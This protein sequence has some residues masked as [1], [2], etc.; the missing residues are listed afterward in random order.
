M[1]T[2]GFILL[3]TLMLTF[4]CL[5]VAAI[6]Y[7]FVQQHN[8][9]LMCTDNLRRIFTALEMYEIERGTLPRLAFFPNDPRQDMDSINVALEEFGAHG[10][11]CICPTTH[12]SHKLLGL[13][14]LWNHDLSGSKLQEDKEP[15]WMLVEINALSDQVPA[16]HLGLYNILYSDGSVRRS[17][18]PPDGLRRR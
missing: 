14:Y 11:T 5:V 16:P 13:T 15:V 17:R 3:R 18:T 10:T 7:A 8:L 1:R 2:K 6:V 12:P 9:T 4:F